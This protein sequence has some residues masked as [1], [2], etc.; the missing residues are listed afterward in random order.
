MARQPRYNVLDLTYDQIDAIER[1]SG[2][3]FAQWGDEDQ[4]LGKLNPLLYA[5]FTG[6]PVEEMRSLTPRQWAEMNRAV[7]GDDPEA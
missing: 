7:E 4:P 2:I 5:A 3:P 1:E 6:K